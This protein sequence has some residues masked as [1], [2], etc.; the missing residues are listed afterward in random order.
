MFVYLRKRHLFGNT[1]ACGEVICQVFIVAIQWEPGNTREPAVH[2]TRPS[3]NLF[4][5][6]IT[7]SDQSRRI[8]CTN[9]QSWYH[10]TCTALDNSSFRTHLLHPSKPWFC[11][12]CQEHNVIRSLVAITAHYELQLTQCNTEIN[13]LTHQNSE[14]K[15]LQCEL[16]RLKQLVSNPRTILP[17]PSTNTRKKRPRVSDTPPPLPGK[18]QPSLTNTQML[19][20]R[21][22]LTEPEPPVNTNGYS[23]LDLQI[24]SS[25]DYT[26]KPV[27]PQHGLTTTNE[28]LLENPYSNKL[29]LPKKHPTH[30]NT[31]KTHET[32]SVICSKFPEPTAT[33]LAGRREEDQCHWNK[34]C[35]TMG[36]QANP[37][38]MTRLTR[39]PNSPHS[40]EPRLM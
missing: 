18:T 28:T 38:S 1:V 29:T 14:I 12:K 36:V 26:E 16:E 21:A 25:P 30:P 3:S 39:K 32:T 4:A 19:S 2:L 10:S 5:G 11:N 35:Q 24:S 34:L 33:S 40:G 23:K 31:K 20:A 27:P 17:S 13:K 22:P 6:T 9:C 37:T 8:E 7:A 15:A